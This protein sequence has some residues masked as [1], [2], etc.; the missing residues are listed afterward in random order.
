MLGN[1]QRCNPIAVAGG[2]VEGAGGAVESV[3]IRLGPGPLG[4]GQ[5]GMVGGNTWGIGHGVLGRIY[6][7]F[8]GRRCWLFGR[9]TRGRKRG[10]GVCRMAWPA[11]G[12]GRIFVGAASAAIFR[13][14]WRARTGFRML[15]RVRRAPE[16][17]CF[18]WSA[19]Q[20]SLISTLPP[21]TRSRK[22]VVGASPTT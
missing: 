12:T 19:A 10:V 6:P 2:L 15:E 22:T 17:C 21:C 18:P 3:G 16:G 11:G 1:T 20:S 14:R 4:Q 9:F 5:G 7:G 13:S 8:A